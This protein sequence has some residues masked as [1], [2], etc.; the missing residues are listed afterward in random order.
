MAHSAVVTLASI[1]GVGLIDNMISN[2]QR[3]LEIKSQEA[4][5]DYYIKAVAGIGEGITE[6][7]LH[8]SYEDIRM[9]AM[10]PE[11]GKRVME[12]NVLL[13]DRLFYLI[14]KEGIRLMSWKEAF[15]K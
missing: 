8:P 2:S 4:L 10:A 13:G 9:E 7:F 15:G 3:P 12:L 1:M 11:W 5:E 6:L 14:E